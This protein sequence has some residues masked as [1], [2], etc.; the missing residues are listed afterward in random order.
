MIKELDAFNAAGKPYQ[1]VLIK[2]NRFLN[3]VQTSSVF[4]ANNNPGT[5][6]SGYP[7]VKKRLLK[8]HMEQVLSSKYTRK[9]LVPVTTS[10]SYG[11]PFTFYLTPQKKKRQLAEV[12]HFSSRAGYRVGVCHGYFRTNLP[13]SSRK[14]WF[15]N[16]I[17]IPSKVL[18]KHF[19]ENTRSL[20]KSKKVKVLIGFPSAMA[21]LA[22]YCLEQGDR[23]EEFGIQGILAFAENLTAK[24]RDYLV[25]AFGCPVH[26]RYATE[27]LGVL[28][29]QTDN[30]SGF[31][32]NSLNYIIEVLDLDKDVSVKPG[33]V[34][35]VV[36]TDLHSDA[37]PL[38]RYETGDLAQLGQV[39]D[40]N[41]NWAKSLTSLS[42][43]SVQL[44][45]A[46]NGERLYPLYMDLFMEESEIFVQYQMIQESKKLFT[47]KLVPKSNYDPADFSEDALI[48]DLKNWL[49]SDAEINIQ[50]VEDI[51]KLPSGKRPYIINRLASV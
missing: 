31:E 27:E 41:P 47:L 23:P 26:S 1:D 17:F 13:K 45:Y 12:I 10:G 43:R 51:E 18:D 3:E 24:H 28:G 34:G 7:I 32:L 49:G 35:R 11:V 2:L 8:E 6:L 46:T 36:V 5:N 50:L 21:L 42:G 25:K 38:I 33:E 37:M 15:Q 30:H 14:L 16:Q 29:Y 48:A 9:E 19:L 44:L 40:E 39:F 4:Y 22:T 20:L